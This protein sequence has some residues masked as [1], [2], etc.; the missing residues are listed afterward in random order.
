MENRKLWNELHKEKRHQLKYPSENVIR[1]VQKNFRCDG[2]QKILDLGCGAG[3][4]VIYLADTDIIPYGGDFSASGVNYTKNMLEQ[5]G[6]NRFAD[7]IVETTTYN[8]PFADNSFDGLI[9][10]G[11]L[12]YMDREHIQKSVRE[13]HR[14]LKKDALA[15]ILIRTIEDY[16]CQD[17]IKSGAKEVEE[18]TYMLVEHEKNKSAIKEN[19]MLMH[20]FTRAEVQEFFASF[21]M[22]AVDTVTQ[23]YENGS[24]QDQDFLITLRK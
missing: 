7:N 6:Y 22:V 3:R 12:Y 19:G 14:V 11:V 2:T 20:F 21:A 8:L 15:L 24:Y 23:T 18:H 10:W 1:F 4:H 17:A 9:C 16:R 13:I 5:H